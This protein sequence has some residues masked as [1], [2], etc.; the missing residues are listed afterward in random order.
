MQV[1]E[2][3][4]LS[5]QSCQVSAYPRGLSGSPVSLLLLGDCRR[6][7][8]HA[9]S[10]SRVFYTPEPLLGPRASP[11]SSLPD[12]PEPVH[13]RAQSVGISC[14]HFP[15]VCQQVG[16]CSYSAGRGEV[17]QGSETLVRQSH[18]SRGGKNS[19]QTMPGRHT[20]W[21]V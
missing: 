3:K 15:L 14:D 5:P 4:F 7:R 13:L 9:R 18:H 6:F 11:L 1:W 2:T 10:T 8:R 12:G 20:G 16:A 17:V 21:H 19:P